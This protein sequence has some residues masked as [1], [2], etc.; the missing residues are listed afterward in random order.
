[1][2]CEPRGP[3]PDVLDPSEVAL[4][5]DAECVVCSAWVHFVLKWD[6]RATLRIGAVQSE[7]GRALLEYAGL[8]PDDVDTMLL[9][10]RGVPWAKSDAFL[11]ACR[12]FRYPMRLARIAYVLPRFLRDWLYDRVAKNRYTLFGKKE[13]C[14]IPDP[15]ARARFLEG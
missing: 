8:D 6:A 10:E 4:L 14:L 13:L 9:V 3:L 11:R 15:S 2:R 5:F 1:M 7:A 12:Y